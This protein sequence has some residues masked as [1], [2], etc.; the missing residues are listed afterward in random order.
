MIEITLNGERREV[1]P[2]TR[3]DALVASLGLDPRAV[4]IERNGD[5][6]PRARFGEV[7]LQ[8]GDRL[9]LVRF[10]QGG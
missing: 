7:E 6:L 1:V 10:V 2:G 8:A 5:V 9:E 4:A 3:V